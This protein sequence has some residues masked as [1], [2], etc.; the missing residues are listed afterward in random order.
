M[1]VNRQERFLSWCLDVAQQRVN[2]IA[3]NQHRGSYDKAAVLTVACAEVLGLRGDR[4]PSRPDRFHD[5]SFPV[6]NCLLSR[7]VLVYT[8]LM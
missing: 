8:T 4:A 5:A 6:Q 3:S 1:A 2:A 7:L